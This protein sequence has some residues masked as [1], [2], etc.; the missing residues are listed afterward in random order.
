MHLVREFSL[1]KP[2]RSIQ[3]FSSPSF[4]IFRLVFKRTKVLK[5]FMILAL[6]VGLLSARVIV[7]SYGKQVQIPDNLTRVSPLH[8]T[9][10]QISLMLG[11]KDKVVFNSPRVPP[12][13]LLDRVF[14]EIRLNPNKSGS[15]TSSTE[16]II[17][18]KP[19]VVFGSTSSLFDEGAKKQLETAGIKVII[20]PSSLRN[21]DEIKESVRVIGEIYGGESIQKAKKWTKFTEDNVKFVSQRVAKIKN[22]KR[23]LY[24]SVEAGSLTVMGDRFAGAEYIR[25]AGGI[26][27]STKLTHKIWNIVDA[28][29]VLLLDP[30]VIISNSQDSVAQILA[31]P[32]FKWLKAVQNKQIFVVPSGVFSWIPPNAEGTMQV[33]WLAKILYPELFEDLNL[34]QKISEFYAMLYD[35]KLSDSELKEIL[36]PK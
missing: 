16:T 34:E 20:L 23:V 9:G 35:Y 6:F 32:A 10:L 5:K 25:L 27:T 19:Q 12:T 31:N 3:N 24:L 26:N 29:Q 13:P 36:N 2:K 28:E 18:S 7:D 33:L 15:H 8:H 30:D 11:S 21:L 14:P 4:W 22:K 1:I 17:A